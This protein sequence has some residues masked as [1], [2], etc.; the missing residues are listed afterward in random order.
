MSSRAAPFPPS[1]LLLQQ[2]GHLISSCLTTGLTELR[3]AHVHNK[4]AFYSALLN[5][6]VGTERLLKAAIIID[7]ILKN[8]LSVPTRKQ[9]KGYGHNLLQ[10]HE[11][12]VAI[13]QAEFRQVPPLADMETN[14]REIFTLLNDFAQATRYHN[15]DALSSPSS[16][17]DP[18][19]QWNEILHAI[20]KIDVSTKSKAR[21]VATGSA[22]AG[23]ISENTATLMQGLDK[24]ALSTAH[25]LVLP[26]L[27]EQA[28]KHAVLYT[29]K[30]L[31]PLRDLFSDLCHTAY[32]LGLSIPPIPQ[33]QE[34]F[35]W[36]W[37]DRN[38]VLRKKRWP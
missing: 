15:L 8:K 18:L 17:K 1:F 4:G 27:H 3:S 16:S 21:I 32:D 38:Y 37:D 35:E 5:L 12:C 13:S 7:H 11:S 29:V 20:L 24:Q 34:F 9:L 22:I 36:L 10:L 28:A 14:S 33:M 31:C 19:V 2:E 25:A 23:A 6:S 26:G 30:F